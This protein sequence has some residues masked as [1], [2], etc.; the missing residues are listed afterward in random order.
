MSITLRELASADCRLRVFGNADATVKGV[1]HDSREVLQGEL[2]CA[3]S[4]TRFDG[5]K[6]V[7]DAISRGAIA[8][9]SEEELPAAVPQLITNNV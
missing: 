8:V 7:D 4:G 9:M 5:R 3:I 2:F 1:R 6:F